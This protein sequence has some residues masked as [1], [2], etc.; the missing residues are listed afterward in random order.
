VTESEKITHIFV[1]NE[2]NL[3]RKKWAEDRL[4]GLMVRVPRC[5]SR[6]HGFDSRCYQIFLEVVGLERCPLSLV[7]ITEELLEWKSRGSGF[8][9]SRLTA[10]VIRCADHAH[11]LSAKVRNIF[12]DMWRSLGRYS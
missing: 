5:R 11:P 4:C 7:S 12:A 3:R 8:R 6:D 2:V 10:V 9:K 1:R